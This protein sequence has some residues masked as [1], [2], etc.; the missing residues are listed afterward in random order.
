MVGCLYF[1]NRWN[2]CSSRGSCLGVINDYQS[3]APT[4]ILSRTVVRRVGTVFTREREERPG[5]R[6]GERGNAETEEEKEWT[7]CG[8]L[9]I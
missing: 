6:G 4:W 8:R 1:K 2:G 9:L 3:A 7:T 5:G